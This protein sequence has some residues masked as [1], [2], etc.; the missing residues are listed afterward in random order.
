MK[1]KLRC[2]GVM[3]EAKNIFEVESF[4]LE[5]NDILSGKFLDLNK[6]LDKFLSVMTASSDLMEFLAVALED[7]DDE[8]E[9]DT[10][11]VLDKKSG[12]A[13]FCAPSDDKKRIALTVTILN[14]IINGKVNST[15]F[16][17]S[18]FQDKKNSPL[19]SFME[20]VIRPY[21]DLIC[22]YFEINPNLTQDDLKKHLEEQKTQNQVQ[23]EVV[24]KQQFPGL[25]ELMD[26]IVK[27]CNQILALLKF[28]KKRTD[29]LDDVEFVVNSILSAC[30]KKNLMVV[31]GLVI[32]LNYVS[33]KFKNV[34]HLVENLNNLIYDYYESLSLNSE[35]IFEEETEFEEE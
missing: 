28:E 1:N 27:T 11:F 17:E 22:K 26:E 12:E 31:N 5:C 29:V 3:E 6:R 2:G 7:F 10:A 8:A 9:F 18:Y 15:K 20:K 16:L 13:K 34:K 14:N 24:E 30:E 35:D 33:K 19:K 4:V 25:D 23:E 32:G 21:R